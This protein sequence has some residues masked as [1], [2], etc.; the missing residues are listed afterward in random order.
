[1]KAPAGREGFTLVEVLVAMVILA[2]GLLALE[3][4]GIGAARAVARA[5]VQ[6][7]Y[8]ALA[9][10]QME[11]TLMRIR[12]GLAVTTGPT[13]VGTATVTT[14]VVPETVGTRRE[15][16]VTVTVAPPSNPHLKLKPV[17]LVAR[18]IRPIPTP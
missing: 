1:M 5:D 16:T 13:P 11:E 18:E 10:Q 3:A 4:L 8:T 7:E 2:V 9:T 6:S 17:T 12:Q 14:D 15:Y